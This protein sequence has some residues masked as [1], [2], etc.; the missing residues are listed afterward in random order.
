M[1]SP[2]CHVCTCTVWPNPLPY[3]HPNTAHI[4]QRNTPFTLVSAHTDH[5]GG[6]W[7]MCYFSLL[8]LTFKVFARYDY[9]ISGHFLKRRSHFLDF[10]KNNIFYSFA[11]FCLCAKNS[12][13]CKTLTYSITQFNVIFFVLFNN[14]SNNSECYY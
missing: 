13:H 3:I 11:A 5:L 7:F 6:Y 14:I 12:L 4:V 10:I 2:V 9:V 8:S 1:L